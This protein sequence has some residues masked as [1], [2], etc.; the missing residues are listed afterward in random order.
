MKNLQIEIKI[1]VQIND[2]TLELSKEE[3]ESLHQ[4]LGHALNKNTYPYYTYPYYTY[5]TTPWTIAPTTSGTSQ[6]VVPSDTT[7]KLNYPPGVR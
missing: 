2:T 4:T 1:K 6:L 7:S 5:P 3:A